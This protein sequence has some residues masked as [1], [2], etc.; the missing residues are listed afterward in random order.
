MVKPDSSYDCEPDIITASTAT[1]ES[2]FGLATKAY[3]VLD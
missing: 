1:Q 3:N 2:F